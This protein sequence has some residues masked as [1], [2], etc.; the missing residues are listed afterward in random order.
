[1][2]QENMNSNNLGQNNI[3]TNNI[4]LPGYE[5]N[6]MP[7]QPNSNIT[8]SKMPSNVNITPN[9]VNMSNNIN[10]IN[11]Q[12]INPN[13]INTS[14]KKGGNIILFVV[15]ILI[16]AFIYFIDDILLYFNQNFIP[17]VENKVYENASANLIDGYIKI[18]ENNAYIK[19]KSIKFDNVRKGSDN[20][21]YLNY[22]SD[23]NYS[24]SNNLNIYIDFYNSNKELVKSEK[25]NVFGSIETQVS[26]QYK[27]KF[28]EQ[29][30]NDV[31]Y[32]KIDTKSEGK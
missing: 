29:V 22:S 32:V 10:Q 16:A 4:N 17:V 8:P 5:P 20:T 11:S 6:K 3:Q 7:A 1:M 25:F 12:Q 24:N 14:K 9:V 30:Y 27:V 13:I 19:I 18:D 15:L 31:Y 26:R 23:K 21:I 28:T 2:N